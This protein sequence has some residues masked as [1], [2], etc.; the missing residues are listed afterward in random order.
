MG[1]GGRPKAELSTEERLVLECLA[2]RRKSAQAIAVRARIVINYAK[3]DT[4]REVA[5]SPHVRPSADL[6]GRELADPAFHHVEPRARRRSEVHSPHRDSDT[7]FPQIAD[8]S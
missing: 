3:K 2:N 8:V 4:N 6:L 5:A 1:N 7:P